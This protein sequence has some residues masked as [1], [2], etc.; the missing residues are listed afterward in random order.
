MSS[1]LRS[2]NNTLNQLR[3]GKAKWPNRSNVFPTTSPN[4][5]KDI[6]SIY[7]FGRFKAQITFGRFIL[8]TLNFL[9]A[10]QIY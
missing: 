5:A 9:K 1:Q 4:F 8:Y 7:R 2:A 10:Q 6:S 3:N